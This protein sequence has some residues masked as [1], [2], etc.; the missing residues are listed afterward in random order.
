MAGNSI[1][2]RVWVK[3]ME[4]DSLVQTLSTESPL[5]SVARDLISTKPWREAMRDLAA[6]EWQ[7]KTQG[8][9]GIWMYVWLDRHRDLWINFIDALMA[10]YVAEIHASRD[11]ARTR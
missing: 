9:D 8:E 6:T 7:Y 10:A 2:E 1:E 4:I 5:R 3:L 11:T